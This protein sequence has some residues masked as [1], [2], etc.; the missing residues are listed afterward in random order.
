[1]ILLGGG[2]LSKMTAPV[3]CLFEFE[4]KR[5]KLDESLLY[6]TWTNESII[7]EYG[8]AFLIKIKSVSV[9]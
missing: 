5:R 3:V 8:F 4:I 9:K 2:L 7:I 1:M 6:Y